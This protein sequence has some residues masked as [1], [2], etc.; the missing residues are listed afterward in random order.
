MVKNVYFTQND[1]VKLD[2][3]P[4]SVIP[5]A[6]A[7]GYMSASTL[8]TNGLALNAEC[9]VKWYQGL[10]CLGNPI[11]TSLTVTSGNEPSACVLFTPGVP[12]L[13]PTDP[14][15]PYGVLGAYSA[16]LTCV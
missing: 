12:Q 13:P 14:S 8:G 15:N 7:A 5:L 2:D 6:V 11:G 4:D 9:T 16:K 10:L 3:F 1:C